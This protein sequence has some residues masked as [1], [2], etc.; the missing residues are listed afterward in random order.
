MTERKLL[1]PRISST[2]LFETSFRVLRIYFFVVNRHFNVSIF[3]QQQDC[4]LWGVVYRGWHHSPSVLQSCGNLSRNLDY[5]SMM[6]AG[7]AP[8]NIFLLLSTLVRRLRGK[9]VAVWWRNRVKC[10]IRLWKNNKSVP[11]MCGV[12]SHPCCWQGNWHHLTG[13]FRA[14]HL[15]LLILSPFCKYFL[16]IN[17]E[18]HAV[19][20]ACAR[21][22]GH[23]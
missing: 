3:V 1:F 18:I 5:Y 14:L 21:I 4:F 20:L 12:L 23:S 13:L 6:Q 22:L 11:C 17:Q 9:F 19:T 16:R 15:L 7:L 2:R 10:F 8:L